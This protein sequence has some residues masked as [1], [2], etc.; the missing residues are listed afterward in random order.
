MKWLKK[1]IINDF[2]KA[3]SSNEKEDK[4]A[5]I[6]IQLF[7]KGVSVKFHVDNFVEVLNGAK[8]KNNKKLAL[9]S[10]Q[11]DTPSQESNVIQNQLIN[12]TNPSTI[13]GISNNDEAAEQE[14]ARQKAVAQEKARQEAA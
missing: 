9:P 7:S 5:T 10:P 4:S 13:N 1:N 14:K 3:L 6:N 11:E 12:E 2:L 8:N